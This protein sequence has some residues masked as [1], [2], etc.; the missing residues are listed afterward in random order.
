ML[1]LERLMI[2]SDQAEVHV[3]THCGLMGYWDAL[4]RRA[5]CPSTKSPEHVATMRLPYACKL[6]FQELQAMNIVPRLT[7]ADA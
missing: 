2:S 3:C 4:S 7:L 6:L 5:L 1:L